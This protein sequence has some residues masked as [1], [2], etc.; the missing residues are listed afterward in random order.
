[1]KYL[2]IDTSG[3]HLTVIAKNGDKESCRFVED[4]SVK[5][6][7]ILMDVIENCLENADLDLKDCDF[8]VAVTGAGSFTG[9]RIGVATVKAL[10]F[11][12]NKLCLNVT[13]FDTLAYN[14]QG[15]KVLAV[16]DARHNAFY[17][18][19]YTDKKVTFTPSFVSYEKLLELKKEYDVVVTADKTVEG[20]KVSLVDGLKNAIND[21][22]D[23]LISPE[24]L[25]PLYIR[26]S[27]AEE[28]R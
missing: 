25:E 16:I 7:V 9:I 24:H 15:G 5:H 12:N 26:K 1:M 13:S 17:V 21:K 28:G 8:F 11:A 27:Q 18:A 22:K 2:A 3:E 19:G 6:S 14:K 10:A 23:G 20:E 4:C